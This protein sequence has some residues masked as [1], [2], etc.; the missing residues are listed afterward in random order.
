MEPME[1]TSSVEVEVMEIYSHSS[2]VKEGIYVCNMQTESIFSVTWK[3]YILIRTR[4]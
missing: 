4:S 3:I 1:C 2:H